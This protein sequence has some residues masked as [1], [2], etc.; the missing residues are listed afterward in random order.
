M[1]HL[2]RNKKQPDR[3]VLVTVTITEKLV[4]TAY[5]LILSML[6]TTLAVIV[7]ERQPPAAVDANY[8]ALPHKDSPEAPICV[9]RFS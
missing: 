1:I 2:N 7:T 6:S 8:P 9:A 5:A 3:T 4:P